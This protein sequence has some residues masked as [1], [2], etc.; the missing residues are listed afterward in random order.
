[1][2]QQPC[3]GL[4]KLKPKRKENFLQTFSVSWNFAFLS[5]G[6]PE[7]LQDL[8][9][10]SSRF[11]RRDVYGAWEQ[12]LGLEHSDSAP[13]R[14]YAA[15]QIIASWVMLHEVDALKMNRTFE[16]IHGFGYWLAPVAEHF[17]CSNEGV[18]LHGLLFTLPLLIL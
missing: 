11:Q 18:P 1:M 3:E 8:D 16:F 5:L 6:R 17:F 10:V 9:I 12:Y 15:N 4:P 2:G 7:Y 14:A 13:K